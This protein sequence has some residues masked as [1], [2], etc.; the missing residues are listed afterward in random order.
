MT[1]HEFRLACSEALRAV[2]AL[3]KMRR[4]GGGDRTLEALLYP[5]A[6]D[7][8]AAV[9]AEIKRWDKAQKRKGKP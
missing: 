1:D 3:N 2:N 7:A 9:S 4:S 8:Q 5:K 6:R